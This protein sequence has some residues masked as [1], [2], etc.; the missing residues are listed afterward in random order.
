MERAKVFILKVE[1]EDIDRLDGITI[2][3][4]P[5]RTNTSVILLLC[6]WNPAYVVT[7]YELSREWIALFIHCWL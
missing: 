6:V 7:W 4:R 2:R 5:S 3:L 1:N